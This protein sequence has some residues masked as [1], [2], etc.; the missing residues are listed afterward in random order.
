MNKETFLSELRGYLQILEDQEQEDILE[1]YAQHIDIKIQ[2]GQSE[3]E[4]IRD[5]GSVKELAEGILAAYHVKPGF[6]EEN[7]GNRLPELTKETAAEGKRLL[8]RTGRFLKRKCGACSKRIGRSFRWIRRKCRS[9]ASWIRRLLSGKKVRNREEKGRRNEEGMDMGTAGM[10]RNEGALSLEGQRESRQ[11][12]QVQGDGFW[13]N[14]SSGM[15]AVWKGLIKGTVICWNAGMAVCIWSLRL[16]WNLAWLMAALMFG[17]LAVL[18]MAG[19]GML[20]VLQ[21]QGYPLVG[22][23]LLTLGGVLIFGTLSCGAFSLLI[24]RNPQGDF[25]GQKPGKDAEEPEETADSKEIE[26]PE[27]TKEDLKEAC[28]E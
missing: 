9:F 4:A 18:A 28:H 24:R 17:A 22:T 21:F 14:L 23:M 16:F 11:K 25:G 19:L 2:K 5:F 20:L 7:R 1:E 6:P 27:K 13:K 26:Q 12:A 3:E 15:G 10:E 8:E